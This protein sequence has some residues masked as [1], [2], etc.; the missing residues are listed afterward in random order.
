MAIAAIRDR[1]RACISIA[2]N[3]P[4]AGRAFYNAD[5]ELLIVPQQGRLRLRDRTRRPRSSNRSR[6]P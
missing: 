1:H 6:S 4:M 2:I 5:G 3:R